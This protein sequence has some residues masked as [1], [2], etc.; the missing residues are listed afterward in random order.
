[1]EGP[2]DSPSKILV[3]QAW[4]PQLEPQDPGKTIKHV[5]HA[6]NLRLGRWQWED[7]LLIGKL[8]AGERHFIKRWWWWGWHLEF[9][10]RSTFKRTHVN[11]H[12][13]I[14]ISR[15]KSTHMQIER[16]IKLYI[17][18]SK[19]TNIYTNFNFEISKYLKL[20]SLISFP[21]T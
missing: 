21:S 19:E 10:L 9:S 8:H 2:H 17:W 3:T 6:C 7:P 5:V 20:K 11:V 4:E 15:Y 1:M 12:P 16:R 13:D 14:N 18:E